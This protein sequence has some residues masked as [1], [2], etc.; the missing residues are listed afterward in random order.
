MNGFA[1]FVTRRSVAAILTVGV[2]V[3]IVAAVLQ[4]GLCAQIDAKLIEIRQQIEQE[5]IDKGLRFSTAEERKVYV[6][7]RM[8]QEITRLGLD[9]CV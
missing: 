7:M 6:D 9:I 1:A 8:Q 5:I 3:A 2:I 4:F